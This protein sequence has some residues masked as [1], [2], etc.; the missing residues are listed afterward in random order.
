MPLITVKT[1]K[2]SDIDKDSLIFFNTTSITNS[3]CNGF[4]CTG[5]YNVILQ[6]LDGSLTNQPTEI[7][8]NNIGVISQSCD[9]NEA[10]DG[11]ICSSDNFGVLTFKSSGSQAAYPAQIS[12]S[13]NDHS[14]LNSISPLNLC[15]VNQY[16]S[17]IEFGNTY[18]LSFEESFSPDTLNFTLS[19]DAS[20]STAAFII[21]YED[22]RIVSVKNLITQERIDPYYTIV[23]EKPVLQLGDSC[24]AN[25]I[26]LEQNY[27]EFN[28]R[29]DS[30]CKLSISK[31][32]S[33]VGYIRY[34]I[35]PEEFCKSEGPSLFVEKLSAVLDASSSQI[36]INSIK[37][38]STI[39]DFTVLGQNQGTQELEQ[40]LETLRE[41]TAQG[42]ISVLGA[43][44]LDY[45]YKTINANED[46]KPTAVESIEA[47]GGHSVGF[48]FGMVL[49][50]LILVL[51][52]G[53]VVYRWDR[54]HRK[55]KVRVAAAEI[56]M[57]QITTQTPTKQVIKTSPIQQ[58][59]NFMIGPDRELIDNPLTLQT[60]PTE[61][62]VGDSAMETP[63][64]GRSETR[65]NVN[66][67]KR[68]LFQDLNTVLENNEEDDHNE[69]KE[70]NN[71]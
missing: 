19:G 1:S 24:G 67:I 42:K 26:D 44:V 29:S 48:Y 15:S 14:F 35:P 11:Y 5:I 20:A 33:L 27:I 10:I 16:T 61:S 9:F 58:A 12:S 28:I 7:I 13:E 2:V 23:D 30:Q 17:I 64:T 62:D 66:L 59:N 53:I 22:I 68:K 69:N 52:L 57:E 65:D 3:Q 55:N 31:V 50:P 18:N 70:N 51:L 38:G 6:D 71:Q 45:S 43:P 32:D 39:V 21:K 37:K 40:K 54:T 46:T 56:K 60:L 25:L 47:G 34:D 41:A 4:E 49:G 8:P 36:R 63:R